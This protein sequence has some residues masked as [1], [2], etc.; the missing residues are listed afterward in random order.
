MDKFIFLFREA[1]KKERII[2]IIALVL[3]AVALIVLSVSVNSA[4][5]RPIDEFNIMNAFTE[6]EKEADSGMFDEYELATIAVI[7]KAIETG[8]TDTLDDIEDKV[9]M[10]AEELLERLERPSLKTLSK[11]AKLSYDEDKATAYNVFISA[12]NIYALILGGFVFLGALLM[13]GGFAIFSLIISP[14][15][16]V[17]FAGNVWLWVYAASCI[18][19]AIFA[20]KFKKAYREYYDD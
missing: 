3:A 7:Q 20:K 8:D 10:P 11:F 2:G 17:F 6:E 1:E 12:I 14:A 4:V 18:A 15:Y 19:F 16:F 9:G 13:R 5:N